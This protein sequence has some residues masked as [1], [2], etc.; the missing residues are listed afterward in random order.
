MFCVSVS[1]LHVQGFPNHLIN[2]DTCQKYKIKAQKS[3]KMQNTK[4]YGVLYAPSNP[5][6]FLVERAVETNISFSNAKKKGGR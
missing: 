2:K 5:D 3:K 1:N 4:I 6:L